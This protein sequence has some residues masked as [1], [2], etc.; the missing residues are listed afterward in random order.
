[1]K[2]TKICTDADDTIILA[3]GSDL[4]SVLGSLEGDASLSSLWFGNNYMKVSEDRSHF[5]SW[6]LKTMR[7]L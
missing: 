7:Y 4:C 3:Y 5:L 2:D 6:G 1:M